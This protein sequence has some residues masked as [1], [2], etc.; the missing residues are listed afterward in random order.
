HPLRAARRS[1]VRYSSVRLAPGTKVGPYEVVATLG[2]VGM[3]E[4]YRARDLRLQREVA[5]KVVPE[6]FGGDGAFLAR[7]EHEARLAGLLNH[8]NIVAVHDVGSHCADATI[9]LPFRGR[10]H[11]F[12][13]ARFEQRVAADLAWH[14]SRRANTCHKRLRRRIQGGS[15]G[16]QG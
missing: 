13:N 6:A 16:R 7:L 3:A 12:G 1:A 8:P 4:V 2:S 11:E 10:N 15:T 14:Q 9:P 5:L